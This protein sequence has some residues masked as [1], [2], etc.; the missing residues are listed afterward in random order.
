VPPS[1][2]GEHDLPA[3][4]E[5]APADTFGFD[6]SEPKDFDDSFEP[7]GT[8]PAGGSAG[9]SI[10]WV[11]SDGADGKSGSDGDL[12]ARPN[13]GG[14]SFT[15]SDFWPQTTSTGVL[16]GT[17]APPVEGDEAPGVFGGG[18]G[19]GFGSVPP[20][21]AGGPAT[22]SSRPSAQAKARS[23][24]RRRLIIEWGIVL[25]IAAVIAILLRAFVVQAF[26]VPS[27]SMEPTLQEGDRILV[28][29]SGLLAG[30]IGRGDIVVFHHPKYF[31][32]AAGSDDIEDLVKRVI[33]LPGETIVSHGN[34]IFINGKALSE[35]GWYRTGEPQVGAMPIT[36]TKIPAGDYFVMG[37]N[38]TDSCDSR[39]FGVIQGS[40]VVGKVIAIVW[41]NGHPYL[42]FF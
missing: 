8:T 14:Y 4:G 26:F 24:R 10:G 34:T 17:G 39:S 36:R 32:C 42:H 31:P 7:G 29:K 37:D 21:D 16:P 27:P 33:G 20:P 19:G 11:T 25:A 9:G 1:G 30:P 18:I 12:D 40:S 23:H 15:S 38:R 41:R 2:G 6:S 3:T 35:N 28:I 5:P 13:G 22:P